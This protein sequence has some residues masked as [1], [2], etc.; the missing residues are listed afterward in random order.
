MSTISGVFGFAEHPEVPKRPATIVLPSL[1][2]LPETSW[3][4]NGLFIA[5]NET[6]ELDVSQQ[7][8]QLQQQNLSQ[9]Q[10]PTSLTNDD[11]LSSP[12]MGLVDPSQSH[13]GALSP[14]MLGGQ[15][16]GSHGRN[17]S[18]S[19]FK[20]KSDAEARLANKEL[21]GIR[22]VSAIC[23]PFYNIDLQLQGGNYFCLIRLR[24]L[25]THFDCESQSSHIQ[26]FQGGSIIVN[27]IALCCVQAYEFCM[28]FPNVVALPGHKS[29]LQ[30]QIYLVS[31]NSEEIGIEGVCLCH[32]MRMLRMMLTLFLLI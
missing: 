6:F 18:R 8:N 12:E 20:W 16:N 5:E 4:S 29:Q 13:S 22:W 21:V 32:W 3:R 7:Q 28:T 17:G 30:F 26:F 2:R 27:A 14:P 31:R 19:L 9:Q 11:K 1:P 23:T 15:E 10:N 25:S 24:I